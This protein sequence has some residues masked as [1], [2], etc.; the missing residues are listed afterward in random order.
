MQALRSH[1]F[2]GTVNWET[3]WTD[4][5]PPLE[6]G[7]LK[8]AGHPLAGARDRNWDDVGATWDDLGGSEDALDTDEMEWAVDGERP[9]HEVRH[10]PNGHPTLNGF[11]RGEKAGPAAEIPQHA[12]G[13][14]EE[15]T[16][17]ILGHSQEEESATAP[18]DV[19]SNV[20]GSGSGS[21]SS[22]GSPTEQLGAAME[23]MTIGRGRTRIQTPIQGNFSCNTSDWF[24]TV[25]APILSD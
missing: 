19:P 8:R 12:V 9:V 7:L 4:P 16:E 5:A 1:P 22:D 18:I 3:L 13:D 20:R 11:V 17:T 21:S 14:A 25:L 2:F 23:A 24:V 6:A 10:W 15:D